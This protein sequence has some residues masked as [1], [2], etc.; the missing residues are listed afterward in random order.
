MLRRGV[1][2]DLDG[3][4]TSVQWRLH[5]LNDRPRN[6]DA[7][8]AGMG[9]DAPVP[10]V[11]ELLRADHGRAARLIV[12]GRPDHYR[13]ACAHWL[14]RHEVPYEEL[15]MRPAGD[16]R[17]DHVV[18]AELYDRVI[19]PR[20]EVAFVVDDRPEVVR[21][22]RARGLHVIQ[23]TDPGLQPRAGPR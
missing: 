22:W 14:D 13:E 16:Y 10:W 23:P 15:L 20:Y 7:F 3:T 17:P 8:F 21:M 6:W 19:A 1:I 4:L 12:T 18:K 2:V 9:D 5:H 11:V